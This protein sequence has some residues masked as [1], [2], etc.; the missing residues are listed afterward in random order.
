MHTQKKPNT[1][2]FVQRMKESFVVFNEENVQKSFVH[3]TMHV[4]L[5]KQKLS[6]KK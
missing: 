4:N 3:A 2:N 5:L 1:D 6:K